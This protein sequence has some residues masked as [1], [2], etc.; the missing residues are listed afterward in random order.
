MKLRT[1]ALSCIVLALSA[2]ASRPPSDYD[3]VLKRPRPPTDEARRMECTWLET[4]LARERGLAGYATENAISPMT[5]IAHQDLAQRNV[6]VLESRSK[7]IAC[8]APAATKASGAAPSGP[9][10]QCFS[11]CKQYTGRNN[12]QCFDVCN[13]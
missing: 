1:V 8:G 2:C 5:A 9:F 13:K 7:R 3:V 12:D 10:D 4:T 11:R 6:A